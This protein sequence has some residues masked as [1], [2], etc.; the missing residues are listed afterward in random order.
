MTKCNH[1]TGSEISEFHWHRWLPLF[2]PAIFFQLRY[3]CICICICICI[4]CQRQRLQAFSA[5]CRID[6]PAHLAGVRPRQILRHDRAVSFFVKHPIP[7]RSDNW[8]W[9]FV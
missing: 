2:A 1:G 9:P 8:G 6:D 7:R 3:V 4:F 5:D